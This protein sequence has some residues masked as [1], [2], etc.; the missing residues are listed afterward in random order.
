MLRDATLRVAPQHEAGKERYALRRLP[1]VMGSITCALRACGA[2]FGSLI[3]G[4]MQGITL[5]LVRMGGSP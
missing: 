4:M 1:G 5:S 2:R 3:I